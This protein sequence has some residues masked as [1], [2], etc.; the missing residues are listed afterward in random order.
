MIKKVVL[1]VIAVLAI[2]VVVVLAIAAS[3]PDTFTITRTQ[4]MKAAADQVFPHIDNF[5]NWREWSPWEEID[6]NLK[7]TYSGPESGNG[8]TYAWDGNNDAGS[9]QMVITESTPPSKVLIKLT[10]TKPFQAENTATF[11]LEPEGDATKVSW[12]MSG[13]N[14]FMMKVM[15]VF[16]SCDDMIGKDFDKGLNKLKALVEKS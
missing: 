4:T 11:T 14:Q 8:A 10:F 12:S 6:P 13:A 2:A 16:M 7:R 15:Q 3:K 1:A 5:H 9:G